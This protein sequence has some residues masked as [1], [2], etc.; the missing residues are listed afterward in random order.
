M[1]KKHHAEEHEEHPDETWLV[2][3]ADVLT[4]LLALFIVLFA[5]SQVDV[6]KVQALAESFSVAFSGT[7]GILTGETSIAPRISPS[8]SEGAQTREERESARLEELKKALE[9]YFESNQLSGLVE[10]R[11][12]EE[13]LLIILRDSL[14][15]RAGS[16]DLLQSSESL[17][18]V[19][20]TMLTTMSQRVVVGGHTD[21][22]PINTVEFPS[23]WDLSSKRAV[24]FMRYMLS[25]ERLLRPER[26]SAIGYGEYRPLVPNNTDTNRQRN[27][28][29]EIM[30]MRDY[31][32]GRGFDTADTER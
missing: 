31:P 13:G 7:P 6:A 10:T 18:R 27:R 25:A 19:I 4:L 16:A 8:T 23:N 24:N 29:V 14:L 17:A 22:S 9:G 30:I 12:T 2:P 28:R 20:A 5:V 26:F 21:N 32:I 1:A 11:L 3:Y 15:F